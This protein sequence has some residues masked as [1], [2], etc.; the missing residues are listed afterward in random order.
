MRR[1]DPIDVGARSELTQQALPAKRDDRRLEGRPVRM[2]LAGDRR[3]EDGTE[4]V[5]PVG[6]KPFHRHEV[7]GGEGPLAADRG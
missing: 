6:R 7:T 5:A 4:V 2:E 3:K 1:G